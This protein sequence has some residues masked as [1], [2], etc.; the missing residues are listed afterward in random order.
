MTPNSMLSYVNSW[1]KAL[2]EDKHEIFRAAHD[3]SKATDFLL[4]LERD[5]SIADE[6]IYSRSAGG[7][8]WRREFPCRTA[9]T[10]DQPSGSRPR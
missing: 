5:K 2:K 1:I 10:R 6:S 8:E 4:S 3:A 9:R 7:G